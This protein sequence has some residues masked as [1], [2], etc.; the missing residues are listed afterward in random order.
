MLVLDKNIVT[1][2]TCSGE[3]ISQWRW[4]NAAAA[5][6]GW[7][8]TEEAVFVLEDGT[9]LIY[10]MFGIFKS[11][12]SMGQEAK[13][14]KILSAKVFSSH[15]GTGVAVMTTTHRFYVVSSTV[16]PRL[17]KLYD[18]GEV[19]SPGAWCPLS[20]DKQS[21]L[22]VGRGTDIVILSVND[23]SVL[24]VDIQSQ[25][26]SA[27][28]GRVELV[29]TS[30]SQS[31]VCVVLDTGLV[32]LGTLS[33]TLVTHQ[34]ET[35]ASSVHW[36]GED[37]VLL[38]TDTGAAVLLHRSGDTEMLFQPV[39]L[40]LVQESDGV[41]I[42]SQGFHDLIHR[43]DKSVQDIY[44][45]GSMAPGAI[46]LMAS[47]ALA[48]KSHK[49]DEYIRMISDQLTVAVSQCISAAGALFQPDH[50]KE[51]MRA[52]KFGTAFLAAGAN[53]QDFYQQCTT[54]KLLNNVRHY[55]VGVPLT[56]VQLETM[57]RRV[58]M[59]RL[60]ARRLFPL[61]MEISDFLKLSP[62][63]GRS[64]VLAHWAMYKVETSLEEEAETARLVSS[65]LGLC[66]D[67]SYS[68]IAEKA[69]ECG[70]KQLSVQLLEHEVRADKQVPLLMKLGQ[71]AQALRKAIYSGDTDLIYHV[72]LSLKDQHSPAEFHMI[73]RQDPVASKL[74]TL[75]CRQHSQ[76]SLG[77]WLRQ[78]DDFSSM[79]RISYQESF[80]TGRVESRL[81]HLVTAQDQFKRCR[82]D[83]NAAVADENHRLL[84]Y[85]SGLEEKFGKPYI[86]LSLHQTLVKLIEDKEYKLA[87]KL[88]SEFK[89]TDRR[90]F[91]IKVRAF[92]DN[93]QWAEL[94]NLAK[95]KKSPIGF[96][97]FID[98]C[99]KHGEKSEAS[100][101]L[102]LL[103]V[104]EKLRYC[105]K[106]GLVKEAAEAA[107]T[108]RDMNALTQLEIKANN[109]VSLLELISGYKQ[110]LQMGTR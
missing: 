64:R 82:E 48:N 29:A 58:L 79:G 43:V 70:K 54:L 30:H 35:V 38:T 42:I 17:R 103:S 60:I 84:K 41:R 76:T 23:M 45:I 21:R 51:L 77:D 106:L 25:Q 88:K 50:Q 99:L 83:F 110:K 69:A 80:S 32:W 20:Q 93:Q 92:G 85:Q 39:P 71:G 7:S 78:E 63:E 8:D 90:Y 12:F 19:I 6:A 1:V 98:Q 16:E 27:T 65:R 28:R 66:P 104:E 102:A 95:N 57:S 46:L 18:C 100:K 59:D 49:A 91:W 108:L 52:A 4:N 75:Y 61:A 109:N 5:A 11:T 87:D 73:I 94:S 26:S 15:L 36:C 3:Q 67:I 10:S 14:I 97:P 9:V 72:I 107:F 47:Q 53:S 40:C 31:K 37:A 81:S 96:G 68:D 22:V 24:E 33:R 2:F 44:R 105:V 34:M 74:Y 89:V 62:A 101:Y 55:K 13:D 86:S 56:N